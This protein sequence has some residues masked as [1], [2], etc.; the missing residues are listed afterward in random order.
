MTKQLKNVSVIFPILIFV[1]SG[2]NSIP[3]KNQEWCGDEGELGAE[4]FNTLTADTRDLSPAD[5]EQVRFGQVCTNT[6]NFADIKA[7][8][9]KLCS[10]TGNCAY[11]LK[12]KATAFMNNV[13]KIK[14]RTR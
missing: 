4:C 7:A 12:K 14:A 3:I 2:C 11:E 6:D 13:N 8:L 10:K 1:L 5:W 9:E